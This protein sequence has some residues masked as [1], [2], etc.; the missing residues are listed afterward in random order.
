MPLQLELETLLKLVARGTLSLTLL[1]G[2]R[3]RA[4]SAFVDLLGCP[5]CTSHPEPQPADD[6]MN[7]HRTARFC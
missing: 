5:R 7:Y 3:F 6:T 2:G 4:P 1:T